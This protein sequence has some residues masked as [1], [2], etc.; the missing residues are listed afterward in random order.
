MQQSGNDPS[1]RIHRILPIAFVVLLWPTPTRADPL[2]T[3]TDLGAFKSL[4]GYPPTGYTPQLGTNAAGEGSVLDTTGQHAYSF[5]R[6]SI[7][8]SDGAGLDPGLVA[9]LGSY[10]YGDT[11]P[12]IIDHFTVN[13]QGWVV[14]LTGR[15][16][17]YGGFS[18]LIR[19][20]ASP[21]ASVAMSY[22]WNDVNSSNASVGNFYKYYTD[23]N[24]VRLYEVV[25]G[26][27][28]QFEYHATLLEPNKSAPS[29][30]TSLIAPGSGWVLTDALKIDDAGQVIGVG[31]LDGSP[32]AFLLTPGGPPTL[33]PVPE[34]T[35]LALFALVTTLLGFRRVSRRGHVST[36]PGPSP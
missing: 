15:D 29:D 24:G 32:H 5:Q 34:P 26:H 17:R 8:H 6:T 18:F 14:G 13:T 4:L 36:R 19:P 11:E 35:P 10:Y 33:A 23:I 25:T 21:E 3:I 28:Y 22:T 16:S 7:D 31:T 12:R 9:S 2:Y 1:G 27:P 30:L 20:G